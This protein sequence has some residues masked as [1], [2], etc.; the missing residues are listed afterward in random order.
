M[1]RHA[2]SHVSVA[3]AM[4]VLIGGCALGTPI[5][6]LPVK[7]GP[8]SLATKLKKVDS[9]TKTFSLARNDGLAQASGSLS[10][11]SGLIKA[12][13][14]LQSLA[15][16]LA[17]AGN[18]SMTSIRASQA[19]AISA[20]AQDATVR[21]TYALAATLTQNGS[22]LVYDD[23]TKEVTGLTSPDVDLSFAFKNDGATRSWTATIL[24][25]RDGTTG[26]FYVQLTGTWAPQ[27]TP[28]TELGRE[29][30]SRKSYAPANGNGAM[31]CPQDDSAITQTPYGHAP[32]GGS[33]AI[34]SLNGNTSGS[35]ER[36]P[37]RRPERPRRQPPPPARPLCR[38]ERPLGLMAQRE[39]PASRLPCQPPRQP[40]RRATRPTPTAFPSA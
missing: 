4:T 38:P 33:R 13:A 20:Q 37:P 16:S 11:N 3:I 1:R 12:L 19:Q 15:A 21:A 27:P 9:M 29:T 36:P 7:T 32:N 40:P 25:S 31:P 34:A 10:K 23:V 24:R 14:S 30:Y 6:K 8:V 17:G 28:A 18:S 35:A 39:P 5:G 26:S 22:T 2:T